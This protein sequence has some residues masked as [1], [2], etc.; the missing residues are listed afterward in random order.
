[1]N[2]VS[3][4]EGGFFQQSQPHSRQAAWAAFNVG[5]FWLPESRGSILPLLGMWVGVSLVAWRKKLWL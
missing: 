2:V 5:E 1:M 3:P 4:T